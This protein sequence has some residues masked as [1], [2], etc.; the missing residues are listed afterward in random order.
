MR[1]GSLRRHRRLIPRL[2]ACLHAEWGRFQP[3]S[4]VEAIQQ[5]YEATLLREGDFI[6]L[7]AMSDEGAFLG[8]A[9]IKQRELSGHPDKEYWLGEVIVSPEMRGNGIGSKLIQACIEYGKQVG[10]PVF[11]LYTPDQRALYERFGWVLI[12]AAMV[13]GEQVSIMVKRLSPLAVG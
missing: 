10:I 5:R 9:S 3:W 6:T 8:A 13:D 7:V 2:A 1:I 4:S 12:E 11:Y